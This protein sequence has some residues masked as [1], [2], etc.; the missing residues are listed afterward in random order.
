MTTQCYVENEDH[1]WIIGRFKKMA[2]NETNTI[3][4]E[5]FYA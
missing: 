4:V 3:Y 1:Q 5:I 2:K